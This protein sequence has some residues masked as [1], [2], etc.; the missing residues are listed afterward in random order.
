MKHFIF[1]CVLIIG[2][3]AAICPDDTNDLDDNTD[4]VEVECPPCER[5]LTCYRGNMRL[6]CSRDPCNS[7]AVVWKD[8][9][10]RDFT[11]DCLR[12]DTEDTNDVDVT[13]SRTIDNDNT[14][15]DDDDV[16]SFRGGRQPARN[17][18]RNNGNFGRQ[19]V[20]QQRGRVQPKLEVKNTKKAG[21]LAAVN[22]QN[23]N[24]NHRN[25]N[26]QTRRGRN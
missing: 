14:N 20:G 15:D 25:Q 10:G 21:R 19:Q 17:N 16:S 11:A 3:N 12:D 23:Q 9:Y 8:S 7:C 22:R 24:R 1:V 5:H 13:A 26:A 4:E 18:Q 2:A 6:F